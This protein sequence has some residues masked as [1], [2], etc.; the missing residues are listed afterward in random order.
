MAKLTVLNVAS[1]LF[2]STGGFT[3]GF[4]FGVFVA[5]IGQPGFYKYFDL[6]PKSS[7]TAS[8]LGA[9][10]SLFAFGAAV[11]AITQGWTGD[12]LGRRKAMF[13]AAMLCIVGGALTAGSVAIS[14]LIVARWIQGVGLGQ[15][16]TLSPLYIGEIAQANRRGVLIGAFTVALG[17]GYS[18]VAWVS[19]GTWYAT[20]ETVQW[21]VPL[22]LTCVAPLF[23]AVGVWFIPESPRWL[24]WNDRKD[25]AWAIIKRLHFDPEDVD[26]VHARAEYTQIVR[27]TEYD[28]QFDVS[29]WQMFKVPSWRKRSLLVIFLLFAGQSTGVLGIGNFKILIYENLGLTGSK[30]IM[31][32]AVY[33]CTGTLMTVVSSAIMDKTGRRVLLLIGFPLTALCLL[34]EA[35][36]QRQYVASDNKAGNAAAVLFLF[37]YITCYDLFIDPISFVYVAEIWPTTLRSKGIALAWFA[38]FV[39]AITYTTPSALAF[40]NI[41]WRM[42]MV[43]VGCNVVSTII[44][45]FF[46]PESANKTMEEMGDLFGDQVM[47]HMANDGQAVVEDGVVIDP[48][49]FDKVC[50]QQI[51]HA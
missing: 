39:G 4:C 31:L 46:L 18:T 25:E 3:Y 2:A 9:V 28:K 30:P 48:D 26:A 49:L 27:Q 22:A 21:R 37:L 14:M 44:I 17:C 19:F 24:I 51:S 36:L 12:W 43:W 29:Y 35:L 16:V 10:N 33:T 15:I 8:I 50:T 13:L 41:G 32:N 23:M 1:V 5:S 20:N 42:Y 7:Y 11:G 34:A 45:Y 6:D 47:T 40:K 38:Y